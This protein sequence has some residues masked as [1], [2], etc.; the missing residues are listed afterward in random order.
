MKIN[1]IS[2]IN[3]KGYDAAPL[4]ALHISSQWDKIKDEFK[5]ICAQE[6]IELKESKFNGSYNQDLMLV[7][8]KDKKPYAL[9]SEN[10]EFFE[11]FLPEIEKEYNM[12]V[13]LTPLF[14]KSGGFISGGNFY[15]GKKADGEKFML[16]GSS[17]QMMTNKNAISKRFD[18]KEENIYFIQQ[19]DYHLDMAIRPIG[20]PY[21]LINNPEMVLKNENKA[22]GIKTKSKPTLDK[23]SHKMLTYKTA[24]EQLK[25][26]G[27]VPI[28]IGAVYDAN[29]ATA[30]F[31]NAIVNKHEDGSISYIT[32][33]SKCDDVRVSKYQKIFEKDLR[34]KLDELRKTDSNIPVLKEVYFISGENYGDSNEVMDNLV[35]GAGGVHCMSSEEPKFDIWV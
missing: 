19:Q 25:Q 23:Q 10:V 9:V 31:M 30:N 18:V 13:E 6:Q 1:S 11:P 12:P 33:S 3:F 20:Y 26:N 8:E 21:V 29:N 32:N 16:V 14:D 7:L 17:E 28:P 4:K 34:K 15:L 35:E 22:R 5:T 2:K 27:F 24:L